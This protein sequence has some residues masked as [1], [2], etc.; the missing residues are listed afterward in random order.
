MAKANEASRP[1]AIEEV[2]RGN[3]PRRIVEIDQDVSAKYDVEVAVTDHLAWID[4]V[5]LGELNRVAQSGI[6]SIGIGG[7][8]FKVARDKL[9]RQFHERART[10]NPF[11]C[12]RERARVDVRPDDLD[13]VIVD[14]GE[15]LHQPDPD[16]IGLFA[17]GARHG[18]DP[19]R[20]VRAP[21]TDNRTEQ[22]GRHTAELMLLAEEVRLIDGKGINEVLDLAIEIRSQQGKIRLERRRAARSHAFIETA[23][24]V[25]TLVVG[26]Q[27]A[28]PAIEEFAK[29]PHILRRDM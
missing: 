2:L 6:D 11:G 7:N 17:G 22:I 18:P 8:S 4:K 5:D 9:P 12:G 14:L 19:D 23:V 20:L 15:I 10:I 13:L 28:G 3:A 16:R 26:K 21:V 24:D 25:V 1:Q 27:H 29:P